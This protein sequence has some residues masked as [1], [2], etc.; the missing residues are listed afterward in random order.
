M[1]AVLWPVAVKV[2]LFTV[3]LA[4]LGYWADYIKNKYR[5]RGK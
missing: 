5:M 4:I 1:M 3:G 2:L